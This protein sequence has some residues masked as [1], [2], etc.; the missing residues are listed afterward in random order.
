MFVCQS[1]ARGGLGGGKEPAIEKAPYL[2]N[3]RLTEPTPI[4]HRTF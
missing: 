3:Q 4:E 1:G 2:L